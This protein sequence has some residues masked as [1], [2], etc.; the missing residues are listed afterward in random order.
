[1]DV[2]LCI[3][4]RVFGQIVGRAGDGFLECTLSHPSYF[5]VEQREEVGEA[6]GLHPSLS[7]GL[8]LPRDCV[9]A[10]MCVCLRLSVRETVNSDQMTSG[11][12]NLP[13]ITVTHA[14]ALTN[15]AVCYN[16]FT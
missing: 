3:F 15:D 1:M 2:C 4:M 16:D 8:H 13:C 7:Q 5:V 11:P 6:K 10:C 14:D 9:C 12:C